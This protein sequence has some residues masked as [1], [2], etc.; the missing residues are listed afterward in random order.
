ME[1]WD[2]CL[3][4]MRVVDSQGE[5]QNYE[6]YYFGKLREYGREREREDGDEGVRVENID[7]M[8]YRQMS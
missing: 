3:A 5:T 1:E 8:C 7:Q 6:E 4:G 2:G